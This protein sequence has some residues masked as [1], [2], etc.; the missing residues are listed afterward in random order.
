MKTRA[1]S[2]QSAK[3]ADLPTLISI[4]EVAKHLGVTVRHVRRLVAERRIPYLKWGHLLRFDPCEVSQWL[5]Q[6]RIE[7]RWCR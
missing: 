2:R 3:A 1:T 7:A 4:E 6:K 5:E